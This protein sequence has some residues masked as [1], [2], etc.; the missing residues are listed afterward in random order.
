GYSFFSKNEYFHNLWGLRISL[1]L[2]W[3]SCLS[4]NI[5]FFAAQAGHFQPTR[6]HNLLF[7]L[8]LES[9]IFHLLPEIF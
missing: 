9:F 7:A 8:S 1:D 2:V 3:S 6:L 5:R 4:G